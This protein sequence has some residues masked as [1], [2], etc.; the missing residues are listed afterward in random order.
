[1]C[2]YIQSKIEYTFGFL[3]EREKTKEGDGA[4]KI[5]VFLK[6]YTHRIK[7]NI[8]MN[9]HISVLMGVLVG[10]MVGPSVG[11]LLVWSFCH[12]FLIGLEVTLPCSYRSICFSKN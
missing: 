12:K 8:P 10:G 1:M 7:F 2:I 11:R 3:K 6:D 9:T 5:E 4:V